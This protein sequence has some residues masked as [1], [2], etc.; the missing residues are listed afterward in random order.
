MILLHVSVSMVKGEGLSLAGGVV[1]CR[2]LAATIRRPH[3]IFQVGRRGF[4]VYACMFILEAAT[5]G[6]EFFDHTNG[7]FLPQSVLF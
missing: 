6:S 1:S 4:C 2:L 3:T 7:L 5:A